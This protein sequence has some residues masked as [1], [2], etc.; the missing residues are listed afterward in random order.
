[1]TTFC[2][3]TKCNSVHRREM[4]RMIRHRN[5]REYRDSWC[6]A[7]KT[8]S[9]KAWKARNREHVRASSRQSDRASY[10]K[11]PEKY[12]AR[13]LAQY[14]E[15]KEAWVSRYQR[16]PKEAKRAWWRI[17]EL[18]RSGRLERPSICSRCGGDG[19]IEAHHPDYNAAEVVEWLCSRC[20]GLT[21]R[22]A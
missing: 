15:N 10:W 11:N 2:R 5:G 22:I 1:M 8:E 14:H 17:H 4:F 6:R 16:K 20:H 13:K 21:R 19:K 9:A 7:C 18:T 3:C 12:R